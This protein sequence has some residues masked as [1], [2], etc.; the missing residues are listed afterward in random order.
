M[1]GAMNFGNNSASLVTVKLHNSQSSAYIL[2][3]NMA[4]LFQ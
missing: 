1:R 2:D 4:N 3:K